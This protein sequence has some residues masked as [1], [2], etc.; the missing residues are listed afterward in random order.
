MRAPPQL[1]NVDEFLHELRKRFEDTAQDQEAEAQIKGLDKE[2]CNTCVCQGIPDC[3]HDWYQRV[4][5]MDIELHW[6]PKERKPKRQLGL[7]PANWK[8]CPG[9]PQ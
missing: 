5:A 7:F 2:L 6:H 9:E 8:S 4:V 1:G 3:I